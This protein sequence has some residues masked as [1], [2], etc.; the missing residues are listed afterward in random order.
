MMKSWGNTR[1]RLH[2]IGWLSLM[3]LPG[4]GARTSQ[5]Q[6]IALQAVVMPSTVI[7]KDGETVKFAIHGFIE[8]K[9]LAEVFPYIEAQTSRW[10][11][12]ITEAEKR[13]LARQLLREGI[14]SRVV[15]MQDVRP[16]QALVTHTNG[17]LREAIARVKKPLPPGYPEQL[18]P[19][20]EK[21]KHSL[22]G[23]SVLLVIAGSV[24]TTA[25]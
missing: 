7:V 8:F 2:R 19:V 5:A 4:I 17:E 25:E 9:S 23:G 24:V 13:E 21:W 11:G 15:S 10:N 20:R 22:N 14:E 18:L 3:L 16:L 6:E 12:K 1:V